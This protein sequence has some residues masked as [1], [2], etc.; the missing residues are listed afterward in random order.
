MRRLTQEAVD[1]GF[2]HVKIKVGAN[3]AE[4]RRRCAIVRQVIGPDRH[5]MIDANQVWNVPQAIEWV[6]AL[7][8]FDPMWIEEP[9][10]PDDI[11]G[12]AAIRRAVHPVGV[13]TGEHAHNRVMFKQMLQAGAIDFVQIDSCRLASVNEVVSVLLLAAK[14]G[15]PVCPHAGGVGLCELV[16]HLAAF[17]YVAVSGTLDGRV[18][19]FVDHLHEHFTD[20]V[21]VREARYVL[22]SKPGYSAEMHPGSVD[23]YRYPDGEY[24]SHR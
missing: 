21:T 4:D 20:P 19:E 17:D 22:P 1:E 8:E 13:A 9:T 7:A 18:V 3:I 2:T 23:R 10:S 11:L 15:V 6:R 16:Q 5:L 14:F 12:H 24:W